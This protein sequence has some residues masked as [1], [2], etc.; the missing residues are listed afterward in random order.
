MITIKTLFL[1]LI[2]L[3]SCALASQAQVSKIPVWIRM[4]KFMRACEMADTEAVKA[5]LKQGISPNTRDM[6]NQTALMRTISGFE[7]F[8]ETN[9][10]IKLLVDA[11]AN[12][13]LTNGFGATPLFFSVKYRTIENNPHD[14][15]LKIG[16]DKNKRD[17]G[18]MT[19][20]EREHED[21]R[22]SDLKDQAMIWR[23]ML[24]GKLSSQLDWN[25]VQRLPRH[26]NSAT[27]TMAG[28][29]YGQLFGNQLDW[30]K[31]E[32]QLVTDT[33][34][35]NYLFYLASRTAFSADDLNFIDQKAANL[36]AS[37]GETPLI[38]AAKFDNGYLVKKLLMSGAR[39]DVRDKNGK[40]ALEYAAEY[41]YF[42]A[43]FM[44]LARADPALTN[45]AGRTPLMIAA[46]GGNHKA[47]TAYQTALQFAATAPAEARSRPSE[48]SKEMLAIATAFR[49]IKVDQM[50]IEGNTALMLAAA[51]GNH[52][53]VALLLAMQA[54]REI[55]N[56]SGKI[57]L[58]MASEKGHSE[59]VKLLSFP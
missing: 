40:T 3:I 49:R 20:E 16:A 56:K 39:A 18:G 9:E 55:K 43:T 17:P 52:Q 50:D 34:G 45:A 31:P 6:F 28:A 44:L 23:L 30:S 54:N 57:A 8:R 5:H 35:E 22:S 10:T 38:R 32:W 37:S 59:V 36:A 33:N 15:L 42:D 2:F 4:E 7:I 25:V 11:G 51:N 12:I 19:F 13:N 26:A 14:L 21:D 46:D 58:Q 41:D 47:V 48:E 29:Y 1:A 24:S 53:I 27:I